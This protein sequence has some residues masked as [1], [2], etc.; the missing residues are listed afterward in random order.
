[1]RETERDEPRVVRHVDEIT[2]AEVD[3]ALA[4]GEE[5]LRTMPRAQRVRYDAESGRVLVELSNGCVFA[6]PP[7]LVQGLEDASEADIACVEV[8]GVGFALNWE[9]PDVQVSLEGLM[10]GIFG[11]RRYM[12]RMWAARAGRA[13]SPAKA[14]AARANGSKG[15]RPRKSAA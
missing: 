4:R 13:T 8:L 14:A 1:M 9:A 12:E 6:F 7:R 10:D 11:T 5:L 2:D 15:G 3:A